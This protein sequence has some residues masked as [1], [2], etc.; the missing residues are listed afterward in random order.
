MSVLKI[1]FVI[2]AL[3]NVGGG[4]ERVLA[5][6]SSGLV[7][8][9]HEITII[10][11]DP[12]GGESYYALHPAVKRIALGIGHTDRPATLRET[13]LRMAALRRVIVKEAPDIAVGFMNS[14]YVPL[15]LALLG[16]AIPVIASEHIVPEHYRNRHLERLLLNVTPYITKCITVVSEQV[17][18]SYSDAL[19]KH[20][21]SIPNIVSVQPQVRADVTGSG[22]KRKTLLTVGRLTAQKDHKSLLEAFSMIAGLFPEWDLHIVG[23][24]SLKQELEIII[25]MLGFEDRIQLPG[26]NPEIAEEY[27]NAQLFVIPSLYESFGLAI[28]EALA[29]G[30]P[31]VGFA[32]C[33]GVNYFIHPG[34]N[35]ILASGNDRVVSLSNALKI[36][37]G[38]ENKRKKMGENAI[39]IKKYLNK[40]IIIE[41][42]ESLFV[43]SLECR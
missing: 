37:M 26:N 15:G 5:D 33:P 17:K 42:W 41:Q 29:Y 8:N 28:V 32:D 6:V 22:R 25:K 38:D 21:I 2:K 34:E 20:M 7:E 43:K 11:Y 24:G 23:D 1:I 36:L 10:T 18:D 4:A 40:E 19:R 39:L 9:G 3:D 27:A 35:G 16:T 13:L 14:V 31:A 12:P 30:L